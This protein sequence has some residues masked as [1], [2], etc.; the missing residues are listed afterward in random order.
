MRFEWNQ[1]KNRSNQA[2]HGVS[3]EMSA[4][5][6]SDPFLLSVQDTRYIDSEQRWY[7]LGCIETTVLY[8]VHIFYEDENGEEI[9]RIIS[10][11]NATPGEERRYFA[12]R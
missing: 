4:L 7:S 12:Q 3:F 8:V 1:T 6:F 5:V 2:K 9:I 10:A 11:R